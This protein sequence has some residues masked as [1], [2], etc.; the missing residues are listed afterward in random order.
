MP[1]I[2]GPIFEAKPAICVNRNATLMKAF[3]ATVPEKLGLYYN[4]LISHEYVRA[5]WALTTS[6]VGYKK[7]FQGT[8]GTLHFF[9][10]PPLSSWIEISLEVRQGY[11]QYLP[12]L[13]PSRA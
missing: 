12:P 13:I 5:C 3:L 11:H 8:M 7:S 10:F 9:F 4:D 2:N 1:T 6:A